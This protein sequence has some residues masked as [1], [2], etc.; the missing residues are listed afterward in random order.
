MGN[1]QNLVPNPSFED[2]CNNCIYPLL[3]AEPWY[4]AQFTPDYFS[5]TYSH[6]SASSSNNP[7]GFQLPKTGVAY[8]GFY[9]HQSVGGPTPACLRE[10]I[11]IKLSQP[12]VSGA[13]YCVEFYISRAEN[14]EQAVNRV[15]AYFSTDTAYINNSP[16]NLLYTPQVTTKYSHA[17]FSNTTNWI[18]FSQSFTAAGGEQFMTIGNFFG[19]DSTIIDTLTGSNF[20]AYYYI[21]DISVINC[22]VGTQENDPYYNINV[23]PS[24]FTSQLNISVSNSISNEIIIYDIT[25]RIIIKRKFSNQTIIDTNSL[26]KGLYIY[27]IR[28]AYKTIKT[29]KLLK[30]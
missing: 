17:V 9:F 5:D 28:D 23:I 20:G 21:D 25:S 16:C 13:K 1:A 6:A 2:T 3:G 26:P 15:G 7:S 24:I 12:L 27:E 10:Y 30:Y 18:L 8:M 4:A 19:D 29:D 22:S 14:F 11:G